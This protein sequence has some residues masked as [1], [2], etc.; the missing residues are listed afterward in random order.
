MTWQNF[1]SEWKVVHDF[2]T[3]EIN[4][5]L[6][7]YEYLCSVEATGFIATLDLFHREIKEFKDGEEEKF[8]FAK[9]EFLK[10]LDAVRVNITR[11][12]KEC[13]NRIDELYDLLLFIDR[14]VAQKILTL[15]HKATNK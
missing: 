1:R 11:Q 10:T 2:I 13:I 14:E 9:Q 7:K 3:E 8:F 5:L 6:L 4:P 12:R 15:H